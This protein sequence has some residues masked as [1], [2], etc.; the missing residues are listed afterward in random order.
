MTLLLA[1]T[2]GSIWLNE[3][4]RRQ[5]G[6]E[7][8]A[9]LANEYFVAV[10]KLL[11][12]NGGSLI[13]WGSDT[14]LGIFTDKPEIATLCAVQAALDIQNTLVQFADRDLPAGRWSWHMK[15]AIHSG[16]VVT[17]HTGTDS[18]M[19]YWLMGSEVNLAARLLE[20]AQADQIVI[21]EAVRP[22][23]ITRFNLEPGV[24]NGPVTCYKILTTPQPDRLSARPVVYKE[25]TLPE[26]PVGLTQE[27]E[28]LTPYMPVGVLSQLVEAPHKQETEEPRRAAM[29]CINVSGWNELITGDAEGREALLD[30]LQEYYTALQTSMKGYGEI[31]NG[32]SWTAEGH[33]LLTV[34]KKS[35]DHKDDLRQAA[36]AAMAMQVCLGQDQP[37]S[38]CSVAQ[39]ARALAATHQPVNRRSLCRKLWR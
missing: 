11:R 8:A 29:L 36:Q 14:L 30:V 1:D 25:T 18:K 17:A 4:I 21:S 32:S 13:R 38:S 2:S 15:I 22:Y 5:R 12:S 31:V 10:V 26:D 16:M 33:T 3:Q 23:L 39:H 28:T 24:S 9:L 27:L 20:L 34:F 35:A 7:A 19:D 6:V 37:A